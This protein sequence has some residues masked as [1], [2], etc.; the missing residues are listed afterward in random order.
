MYKVVFASDRI[1]K[2]LARLPDKERRQ[3]VHDINTKLR[4]FNWLTKGVKHLKA[5]DVYRLRCGDYRVIF[6]IE[7]DKII[8][9]AISNRK[10]VSY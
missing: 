6:R 7:E 1:G 10:D 8:V 5:M 3:I 4:H 2:V 9:T